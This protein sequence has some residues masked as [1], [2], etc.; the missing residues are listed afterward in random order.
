MASDAVKKILAAESESDK[1][2]AEARL[3][4]D[5]IISAAEGNSARTIQKRLSDAAV[6]SGKIRERLEAKLADYNKSAEAE[7]EKELN[8][9]REKAEK[10]M[11]KAVEAII[12]AYF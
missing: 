2:T 11:D 4:R 9:I 1:K 3:R 6:E 8:S 5:D 12:S 10:N 7:C